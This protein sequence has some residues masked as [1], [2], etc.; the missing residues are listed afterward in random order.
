MCRMGRQKTE[1]LA[2]WIAK[3]NSSKPLEWLSKGDETLARHP[4]AIQRVT[5]T[6]TP[7]EEVQYTLGVETGWVEA[8]KLKP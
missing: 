5:I 6:D 1:D 7:G 8:L 4:R 3:T 2:K